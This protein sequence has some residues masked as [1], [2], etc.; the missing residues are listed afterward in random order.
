M[1][2]GLIDIDSTIPNLALMKISSYHK[3]IGD[4]VDFYKNDLFSYKYDKCYASK[5][6]DFSKYPV[7]LLPN[8]IFGGTGYSLDIVL[9][10]YIEYL[11]PDY[12]IYN[13]DYSIGFITRG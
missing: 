1:Q 7:N 5:V 4:Q 9:P 12:A 8:T 13:C 3:S 2:I 6:F 11:M 10:D